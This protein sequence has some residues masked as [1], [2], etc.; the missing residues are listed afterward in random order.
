[1]SD[2]TASPTAA[3]S[4]PPHPGGALEAALRR[5]LKPLVRLLIA[6]EMGLPYLTNL[7]KSIYVEVAEEHFRLENGRLTDS[8]LSVLTGVHRKDVKRLR[9]ASGE[10][11]A[12][13]R[14]ASLGARIIGL[15][16]GEARYLDDQG[17]P[18]PLERETF[19]ALI[20]EVSRDVHPRT[21]RDEWQRRG[22]V[23]QD[24]EGRLHLQSEAFIPAENEEEMAFYFGRN[25]HD[26]V[27]AAVD[28]LL[29][30][31]SPHFERA[32]FYGGLHPESV[33]KLQ[34]VARQEAMKLLKKL[35]HQALECR[36][37]DQGQPEA[38]MHFCFG[39]YGYETR[40][41]EPKAS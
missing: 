6:R 17:E 14:T 19:E 2:A 27:A 5:L 33:A 29:G 15:W 3:P 7:L 38:R 1:M 36:A 35:N 20:A 24:P 11:A 22:L 26:H 13:A 32:V 9:Q 23:A 10:P 31:S 16:T 40:A 39:A 25:L 21:F 30:T 4:G 37:R 34:A 41:R 18:L 8:R 28:N 12:P